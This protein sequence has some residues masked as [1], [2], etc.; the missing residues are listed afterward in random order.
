MESM[1]MRILA[2]AAFITWCSGRFEHKTLQLGDDG[3]DLKMIG[4]RVE[5]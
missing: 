3:G 2:P 1:N 4:R 5:K